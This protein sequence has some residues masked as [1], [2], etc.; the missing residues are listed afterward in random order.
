MKKLG[1]ALLTISMCFACGDGEEERD[2]LNSGEYENIDDAYERDEATLNLFDRC[3]VAAATAFND[4]ELLSCEAAFESCSNLEVA[5]LTNELE[6]QVDLSE[7]GCDADPT[8]TESQVSPE[9]Q[10]GYAAIMP[11]DNCGAGCW[12]QRMASGSLWCGAGT[13]NRDTPCPGDTSD[14]EY[15]VVQIVTAGGYDLAQDRQC[16]RHDHGSR[17]QAKGI[18]PVKLGCDIDHRLVKDTNNWAANGIFGSWGVASVWGCY[19]AGSY[20]CWQWKSKWWGG[21]WSYGNHCSGEHTHYGPWRY[22]NYS[23]NW[24]YSAKAKSCGNDHSFQAKSCP[25]GTVTEDF[26]WGDYVMCRHD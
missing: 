23:H 9:C 19:D 25:Y 13:H 6:C 11:V 16:R 10:A 12:V 17:A 24:G 1:I 8:D 26:G 7:E 20:G 22:S 2:A 14:V 21:Y 4:D 15:W 18:A 5:I 3:D